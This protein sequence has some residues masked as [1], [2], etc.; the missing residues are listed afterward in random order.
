MYRIS[1]SRTALHSKSVVVLIVLYFSVYVTDCLYI[2]AE[3]GAKAV[4]PCA[5]INSSFLIT[6]QRK[7]TIVYHENMAEIASQY[8]NR[9][10]LQG[11]SCSLILSPVHASDEGAYTCFYESSTF[12]Y[13]HVTLLVT[14]NFSTACTSSSGM[15]HCEA[16]QG[17]PEAKIVWR[18]NDQPLSLSP[19]VSQSK[20]DQLTG[21]YDITS[22]VNI[23]VNGTVTC[24]V[25]N[26]RLA[27]II[28]ECVNGIGPGLQM[29]LRASWDVLLTSLACTALL[30]LF[31][32]VAV[33]VVKCLEG[34]QS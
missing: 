23:T 33:W 3:T 28:T 9:T 34:T 12:F 32:M 5:C 6:W 18:L 1:A 29:A 19:L 22:S 25:I 7:E 16:R 11:S 20:L 4:L 2:T 26:S 8:Y 21:L 10:Q 15:Y 30:V 27:R 17:H 13:E 24:E 31:I 14:A